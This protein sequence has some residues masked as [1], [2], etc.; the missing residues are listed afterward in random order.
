MMA[1]NNEDYYRRKDER[2][3]CGGQGIV[4]IVLGASV[5]VVC[6]LERNNL[7]DLEYVTGTTISIVLMSWG[8][9]AF[10]SFKGN[11]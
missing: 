2:R 5:F 1:N 3:Y 4:R 11:K 7:T 8:Y 9:Q 10:L 6:L